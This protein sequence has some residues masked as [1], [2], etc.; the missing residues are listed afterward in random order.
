MSEIEAKSILRRSKRID[1][2]FLSSAGMNL[3]RGCRHG[4]VYCDG[5]AEQYRVAGDFAGDI[6][7]KMNA[8]HILARELDPARKRKPFSGGYILL[9]G[10]VND[11]YQPLEEKHLLARS[12]L[13]LIYQYHHPVHILTKSCLV[14][15]DIDLI[16]QIHRRSGAL[17]SMSFS[18]VDPEISRVFEPGVPLPEKRLATLKRFVFRGIPCGVY[19]MPVIPFVTD[20][21]RQIAA[22]LAEFKKIGVSFVVFGGMT[23]KEGRQT[24]YFMNTLSAYDPTLIGTYEMIYHSHPYGSPSLEYIRSINE[25]FNSAADYFSITKRIPLPLF[26]KQVNMDE[27]ICIILDQ[28]GAL[29]ELRGERTPFGYASY[30]LSQQCDGSGTSVQRMGSRL[31]QVKGVGPR[32][33]HVIEEILRTGTSTYYER[34][35]RGS[36]PAGYRAGTD[37]R[38]TY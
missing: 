35:L 23:L 17:V 22:S 5:R 14:E 16:E 13:E 32:I 33:L 10:G 8:P 20:A 18:S 15:R 29:M 26:R 36:A 19:L 25:T 34:L 31:S 9:G 21:P 1:S 37:G 7:V 12:A 38:N 2:W 24:D 11:S 6:D 28:M 4:C 27:R 30:M 3:Y